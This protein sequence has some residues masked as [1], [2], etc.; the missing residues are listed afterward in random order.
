M[1][2][3]RTGTEVSP[4]EARDDLDGVVGHHHGRDVE[5][6]HLVPTRRADPLQHEHALGP[7]VLVCEHPRDRT[8]A[9]VEAPLAGLQEGVALAE[10]AVHELQDNVA[11][12]I[13]G[14]LPLGPAPPLHGL[15]APD[16]QLP[17]EGQACTLHVPPP[18]GLRQHVVVPR[19]DDGLLAVAMYEEDG[20]GHGCLHGEGP[21]PPRQEAVGLHEEAVL[22]LRRGHRLPQ[23]LPAHEQEHCSRPRGEGHQHDGRA[24][25]APVEEPVELHEEAE[26]FHGPG[27]TQAEERHNDSQGA[28]EAIPR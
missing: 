22:L 18:E 9:S 11:Q 16:P 25:R 6:V 4:I 17:G 20:E 19:V 23:L 26:Q 24:P 1:R 2:A 7:S 3:G 14:G 8:K 10:A 28:A 21:E 15:P 5:G 12:L 27:K 13:A